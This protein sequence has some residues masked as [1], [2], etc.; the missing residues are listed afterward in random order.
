MFS[1]YNAM[2]LLFPNSV[3]ELNMRLRFLWC[4]TT[5]L[6]TMAFEGQKRQTCQIWNELGIYIKETP[7]RSFF[8]MEGNKQLKHRKTPNHSDD[9]RY[10]NELRKI[11]QQFFKRSVTKSLS[12]FYCCNPSCAGITVTMSEAIAQ[13]SA[14][15]AHEASKVQ[16]KDI[17][18]YIC[19]LV[20]Q[21]RGRPNLINAVIVP[22]DG[23]PCDQEASSGMVEKD[24]LNQNFL[25]RRLVIEEM[26]RL[27][28]TSINKEQFSG[29]C[30]G[31]KNIATDLLTGFLKG[32]P[33]APEWLVKVVTVTGKEKMTEDPKADMDYL[34]NDFL[35]EY[36]KNREKKWYY[37]TSLPYNMELIRRPVKAK[38]FRPQGLDVE[39]AGDPEKIEFYCAY[40]LFSHKEVSFVTLSA[41]KFTPNWKFSEYHI[42][43]AVFALSVYNLDTCNCFHDMIQN[44]GKKTTKLYRGRYVH[45]CLAENCKK[46]DPLPLVSEYSVFLFSNIILRLD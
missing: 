14:N 24:I 10:H 19:E 4:A 3:E 28:K 35:S 12:Y 2:N 34:L 36:L 44:N 45:E 5:N 41:R 38:M 22:E 6:H 13:Y 7:I 33:G 18:T 21:L 9:F 32:L 46:Q 16:Q 15:L 42:L 25:V 11:S 8:N 17:S 43:A 27:T 23:D 20:K 1:A 26:A 29:L 39:R 30:D 37:K 31:F 40:W